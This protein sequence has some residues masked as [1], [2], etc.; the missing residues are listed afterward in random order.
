[1]V[2]I[3]HLHEVHNYNWEN[4]ETVQPKTL[5]CFLRVYAY[6]AT[7]FSSCFMFNIDDVFDNNFGLCTFG[8]EEMASGASKV[9]SVFVSTL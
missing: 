8:E 6:F 5:L 7:L 3:E 9:A 4:C 1:M 2:R